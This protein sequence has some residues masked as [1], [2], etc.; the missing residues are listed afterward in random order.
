VDLDQIEMIR[1]QSSKT[2]LES[3]PNVLTAVV[4][5]KRG[6]GAGRRITDE[7]ATLGGQ[8]ILMAAVGDI[9]ADQ[10]LASAVIDGGVDQVDTASRTALR[11]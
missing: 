6:S 10:F 7:A 2:L 4:V 1:L 3:G 8:K 9:A 11:R 5:G